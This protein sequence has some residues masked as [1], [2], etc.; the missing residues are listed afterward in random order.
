MVTGRSENSNQKEPQQK[1]QFKNTPISEE[2]SDILR[3]LIADE[4][5]D[6]DNPNKKDS[7]GEVKS[8]EIPKN[9]IDNNNNRQKLRDERD[10]KLEEQNKK[11]A[12][13]RNR[14]AIL[15]GPKAVLSFIA[16]LVHIHTYM[17]WI[18]RCEDFLMVLFLNVLIVGV[19]FSLVFISYI[20][21]KSDG[22]LKILIFKLV[23]AICV[24]AIC[25]VAQANI[26][27]PFSKDKKKDEE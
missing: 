14:E 26:P 4:D 5:D 12:R 3:E 8:E 9:M 7:I 25:L 21:I 17:G 22:E 23:G 18:Q 13:E 6:E 20:I 2:R 27:N 16:S 11:I 24:A 10:K 1:D 15:K 19:I